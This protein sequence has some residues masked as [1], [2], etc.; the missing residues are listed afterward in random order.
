MTC[1]RMQHSDWG[2]RPLKLSALPGN[3]IAPHGQHLYLNSRL[4][5]PGFRSQITTLRDQEWSFT[6]CLFLKSLVPQ[7]QVA[8]EYA[9]Y[10]CSIAGENQA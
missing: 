2:L 4:N 10:Q 3:F 1:P 9:N 5:D 8:T 6:F 7:K